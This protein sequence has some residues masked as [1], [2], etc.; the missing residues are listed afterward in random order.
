MAK[1]K[2][3]PDATHIAGPLIG[4]D[5]VEAKDGVVKD[6][7]HAVFNRHAGGLSCGCDFNR[8]RFRTIVLNHR[9]HRR[10]GFAELA[11]FKR[12]GVGIP[13][14]F[15]DVDHRL[16]AAHRLPDATVDLRRSKSGKIEAC[17]NTSADAESVQNGRGKAV[18]S[19]IKVELEVHR[20][21]LLGV[22]VPQF[23]DIA[24]KPRHGVAALV[25]DD[26]VIGV[27][28]VHRQGGGQRG[29]CFQGQHAVA[30]GVVFSAKCVWRHAANGHARSLREKVAKA[31][32]V[33]VPARHV[34]VD[35][36]GGAT[37][38][39]HHK[40]NLDVLVNVI[41]QVNGDVGPARWVLS[42]DR[43]AG[44]APSP[45]GLT[46]ILVVVLETTTV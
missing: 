37:G 11:A 21:V 19:G 2:V 27:K 9:R 3:K 1:F 20:T 31:E 41:G 32:V 12:C 38:V 15:W 44:E 23:N 5:G 8:R 29:F 18:R 4:R 35:V 17:S 14:G 33:N 26:V 28:N 6:G 46:R 16:A 39:V 10:D 7:H 34:V 22:D 25:V 43:G 40:S 13:L 24:R 30:V 36:H 45:L 42:G